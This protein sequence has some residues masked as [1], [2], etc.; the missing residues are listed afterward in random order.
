M[1]RFVS[2]VKSFHLA[3]F[4]LVMAASFSSCGLKGDVKYEQEEETSKVKQIIKGEK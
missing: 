3:L 1:K 2:V 4:C